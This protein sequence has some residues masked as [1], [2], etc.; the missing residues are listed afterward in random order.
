MTSYCEQFDLSINKPFKDYIKTKYR[1]FCIINKNTKKPTQARLIKW[2]S[3]IWWSYKISED[4][5]KLSF[6]KAAINLLNDGSE[7]MLF[8][9]PKQSYV[10]LIEDHLAL[11]NNNFIN[12][13]INYNLKGN[14]DSGEEN[15]DIL[16]KHYRY[17]INSIREEVNNDLNNK[18]ENE[19]DIEDCCKDYNYYKAL[20]YFQ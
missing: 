12:N 6:K 9:W 1:E 16:F 14:K 13:S 19:L 17:S 5:I 3:D 18:Y 15:D 10:I 8:T 2:V 7:D 20:G 4:M 11:K